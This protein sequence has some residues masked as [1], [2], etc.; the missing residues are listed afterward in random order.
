MRTRMGTCLVLHRLY[1]GEILSIYTRPRNLVTFRF[2]FLVRPCIVTHQIC[3]T[4]NFSCFV[5]PKVWNF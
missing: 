4:S 5:T 1:I 2:P 3:L